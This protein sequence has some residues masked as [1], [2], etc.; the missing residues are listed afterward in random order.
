ME[1]NMKKIVS[2]L[3]FLAEEYESEI[4]N[5]ISDLNL[6]SEMTE[7]QRRF[8]SGL[9][10]YYQPKNILE[11][12][13]SAGGG[14]T[15][16]LNAIE[17]MDTKL[18]SID[19]LE[20]VYREPEHKVGYIAE[21]KFAALLGKKW[22]L[23]LGKD[24]AEVM[25]KIDTKFDF[26]IIDT[27]H[28]H[29][30]EVLNFIAVLPWLEDDAVVVIHDTTVF[31]LRF[32]YSFMRMLSPRIL[33]SS[34][35][36]EKYI[37]NLPSGCPNGIT[38]ASNIAALQI[39]PDTRKYARNLFDSLY[40]PWEA[41]IED[42]TLKELRKLVIEYYPSDYVKLF[43][44]AIKVNMSI[45]SSKES[46]ILGFE[47]RFRLIPEDTV[48]YGAGANMKKLLQRISYLDLN[49][50]FS[51][52]DKNA[53]HINEILGHKV[54]VPEEKMVNKRNMIVT[55]DNF[56]VYNEIRH[57]YENLGYKVFHG[58]RDYFI[59]NKSETI[60]AYWMNKSVIK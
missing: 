49:F 54:E 1:E 24:P 45:F 13:V 51:I 25:K 7:G 17:D 22:E 44:E 21:E 56:E 37:P 11:L 58:L 40:L 35:C 5:K 43:D 28:S 15:V 32:D 8:I 19:V 59:E 31:E 12:G 33:L 38:N 4:Y 50:N 36:A 6:N 48:F 34:V 3:D 18:H 20:K 9:I 46:G 39:T 30:G 42:K 57:K 53:E 2:S 29:P 60:N 26:C 55:I 10:R 41:N 47:K 14:T 23:H 27:L 52:W 16:I